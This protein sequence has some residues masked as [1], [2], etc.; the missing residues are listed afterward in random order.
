MLFFGWFLDYLTMLQ[1][2][3]VVFVLTIC[4]SQSDWLLRSTHPPLTSDTPAHLVCSRLDEYFSAVK[5][6]A[7]SE[8][9]KY[10]V[11]VALGETSLNQ[12]FSP[13]HMR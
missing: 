4:L 11:H 2:T 13:I 10:D 1:P 7:S 3:F 6:H 8:I 9:A 5:P 12:F